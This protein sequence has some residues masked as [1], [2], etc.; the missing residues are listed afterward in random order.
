M[1]SSDFMILKNVSRHSEPMSTVL[2]GNIF[3]GDLHIVDK[4][5]VKMTN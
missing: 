5:S 1:H 4:L 3:Q 2:K